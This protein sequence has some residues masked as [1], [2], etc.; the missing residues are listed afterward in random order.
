MSKKQLIPNFF[1]REVSDVLVAHS[2]ESEATRTVVLIGSTGNGKSCLGNFLL[3]NPGDEEEIFRVAQDNVPTTKLTTMAYAHFDNIDGCPEFHLNVI[4]TPGLNEGIREDLQNMTGIIE[5]LQGLKEIGACILVV[6]FNGKIDAQYKE[7]VKYY[8]KLLSSLFERNVIIVMTEYATHDAAVKLRKKQKL[9]V[10]GI[11]HNTVSEIMKC[12]GLK[13]EPM[14]FTID[15]V[16]L[17]EDELESNLLVRY[18]IFQYLLSCCPLSISALRVA[19]TPFIIHKDQE[20]ISQYKGESDGYNDRLKKVNQKAE[21]ALSE[22]KKLDDEVNC[23]T[24][25][26][27]GVQSKY[28]EKSTSELVTAQSWSVESE[29]K[30]LQWQTATYDL[31]PSVDIENVKRWSSGMVDWKDEVSSKSRLKGVVGGH[32]MRGLYAN[33][34]IETQK[35]MKYKDELDEL[36]KELEKKKDNF[37]NVKRQRDECRTTHKEF[38]IEIEE[39]ASYIERNTERIQK[40]SL[41]TM[42]VEEAYT[43]LA[44]LTASSSD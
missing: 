2:K 26:L 4:D 16:P 44:K 1:K 42:S 15:C 7:T 14:L 24:N 33:I 11:K 12:A 28:D 6:K 43:R 9:D 10:E 21:R 25:E 22:F 5:K 29:W 30:F 31:T 8:A 36:R 32:F 23:K 35:R 3:N 27:L 38:Q 41:P 19:K 37:E 34:T 40:L 17:D 20:Q 18:S 39:L 13:Y